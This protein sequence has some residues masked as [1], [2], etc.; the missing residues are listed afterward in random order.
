[1]KI[2]SIQYIKNY[3]GLLK[4]SR[5]NL[6]THCTNPG[7][8]LIGGMECSDV[9]RRYSQQDRIVTGKKLKLAKVLKS[10][11]D[12]QGL[13]IRELSR[14]TKVPASTLSNLLSGANVQKIEH[15]LTLSEFFGVT[16][17]H[18][19]FGKSSKKPTIEEMDLEHIFS[20]WLKVKIE[21]AV[22][23]NKEVSFDEND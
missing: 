13:T 15:V 20:G 10:L 5:S 8:Y 21:R 16:M 18:L 2:Y 3:S 6:R 22:P 14:R 12:K 19:L 11:M 9:L 23:V 17:E 4:D 7:F 1:M